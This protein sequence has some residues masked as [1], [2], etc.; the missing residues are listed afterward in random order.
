MLA[1][2]PPTSVGVTATGNTLTVSVGVPVFGTAAHSG[3]FPFPG[4]GGYGSAGT[5]GV[6]NCLSDE[7]TTLE[8]ARLAASRGRP[9]GEYGWIAEIWSLFR[10]CA[11]NLDDAG[12]RDAKIMP[13]GDLTVQDLELLPPRSHRVLRRRTDW[14]PRATSQLGGASCKGCGNTVRGRET[15][16]AK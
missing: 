3:C 4:G 8:G 13:T 9:C 7:P 6:G 2:G 5:A 10:G 15:L 14:R 16:H 11:P 12:L 1:G